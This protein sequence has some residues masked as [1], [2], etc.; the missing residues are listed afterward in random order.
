MLWLSSSRTLSTAEVSDIMKI[1]SLRV[2]NETDL[3]KMIQNGKRALQGS[4]GF[5]MS[6]NINQI[7][8]FD[9]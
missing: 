7:Q 9:N 4:A 8:L 2:F 5:P 6:A 3:R 1:Q